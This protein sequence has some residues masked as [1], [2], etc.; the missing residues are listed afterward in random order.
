LLKIFFQPLS[1]VC[2]IIEEKKK[3][4]KKE[5]AHRVNKGKEKRDDSLTEQGKGTFS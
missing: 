2:H 3:R 1:I 4:R 5:K